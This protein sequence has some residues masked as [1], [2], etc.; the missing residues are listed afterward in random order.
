MSVGDVCV[1]LVGADVRT[2]A[3]VC[4]C[5]KVRMRITAPVQRKLKKT[6]RGKLP[7]RPKE[8]DVAIRPIPKRC[9]WQSLRLVSVHG[10]L[11]PICFLTLENRHGK[12][13]GKGR[14]RP[15][16]RRACQNKRD[17]ENTEKSIR[18]EPYRCSALGDLLRLVLVQDPLHHIVVLALGPRDLRAHIV[19]VGVRGRIAQAVGVDAKGHAHALAEAVERL[20]DRADV[21]R[22]VC[23]VGWV[24]GWVRVCVCVCVLVVDVGLAYTTTD[25]SWTVA[26]NRSRK[27]FVCSFAAQSAESWSEEKHRYALSIDSKYA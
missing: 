15:T 9:S 7:S 17:F 4:T 12:G 16:V 26:D 5:L 11:H 20:A 2:S 21:R 25:C 23:V 14:G 10:P 1:A 24:S 8:G 27:R 22:C 19:H 18:K 3:K 13:D 6:G